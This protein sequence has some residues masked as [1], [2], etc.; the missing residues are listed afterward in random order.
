M[1]RMEHRQNHYAAKLCRA[2]P[3]ILRDAIHEGASDLHINPGYAPMVR[4]HGA[5]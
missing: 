3:S 2:P 1:E 5:S 4:V